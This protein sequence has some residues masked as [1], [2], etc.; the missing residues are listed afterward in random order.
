MEAKYMELPLYLDGETHPATV[1]AAIPSLF[2]YPAQQPS[3]KAIVMCPG[4]GL[5]KVAM[6][7][8]GHDMAPWFI[9]Q[10][11]TFA[12]LKYRMPNQQE[13][14]YQKTSG[15]LSAPCAAYPAN[16]VSRNWE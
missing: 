2:I 10:G 9:E 7:H 4:G 5:T 14:S 15:K 1:N 6:E 8:E 12:I 13:K 16:T 11:I 3:G